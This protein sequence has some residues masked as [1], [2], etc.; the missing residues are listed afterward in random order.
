MSSSSLSRFRRGFT[1]IEL[2]VVIAIIAILIGLLLPAIQKV[3]EAA[4]RSRC[5]N[6]LKQIGLGLHGYHDARMQLPP[7]GVSSGVQKY[8][9]TGTAGSWGLS[10]LIFILPNVEQGPMFDRVD[11]GTNS[12]YS[13][14]NN[15]TLFNNKNPI[16]L[17]RCPS[18]PS[19]MYAPN[20]NAPMQASYTGIAGAVNGIGTPAVT[21]SRN[22]GGGH[23]ILS[24]SG[25]LWAAS[26]VKFAMV[27]DGL[28]N[29]LLVGEQSDDLFLTNGTAAPLLRSG[30]IYG[31]TMGTNQSPPSPGYERQFSC[32][33]IRYP[34]NQR[35]GWPVT[36]DTAN[37]G[38]GQ[39]CGQNHPL[40]S[41]HPGGV[42]ALMADGSVKFL[43]E[44]IDL[45]T[46][47][48]L[49]IRDDRGVVSLP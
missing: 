21:D 49:S 5:T 33:T 23:G 47:A 26:E 38:V 14:T 16:N 35:E 7:G 40:V 46:L 10:W 29:T 42:N 31:F 27:K 28:S 32:T 9:G 45:T 24:R 30:G 6:N 37:N 19:P 25:L 41:A 12:G 43:N 39:D 13:N 36:P 4:D 34:I 48:R 1:L 11:L 17:Y 44:T 8:G 20:G 3:R 2:L 22:Q 18:S 15:N